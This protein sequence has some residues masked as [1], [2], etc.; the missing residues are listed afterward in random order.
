[1]TPDGGDK[2]ISAQL[3]FPRGDALLEL[4][5][6]EESSD[7]LEALLGEDFGS[8]YKHVAS[9]TSALSHGWGFGSCAWN[10]MPGACQMPELPS[11]N[12]YGASE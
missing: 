1:M 3:D 4:D 12:V 11:D 7:Y 10:N 6:F 8:E 9:P 2:E 5:C